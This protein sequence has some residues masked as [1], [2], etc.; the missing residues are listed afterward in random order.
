MAPPLE[1]LVGRFRFLSCSLFVCLCVCLFQRGSRRRVFSFCWF[2]CLS[3]GFLVARNQRPRGAAGG[4]GSAPLGAQ[5]RSKTIL[6]IHFRLEHISTENTHTHTHTH[7]TDTGSTTSR[8]RSSFPVPKRRAGV[9]GLG[10]EGKKT[11]K[12]KRVHFRP[13]V[14][15]KE[16]KWRRK[17]QKRAPKWL[18]TSRMQPAD[19]RA[20]HRA[21]TL[22]ATRNPLE[23][24]SGV[25]PVAKKST[26]RG[27]FR[28]KQHPTTL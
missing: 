19:G 10:S 20:E 8:C 23:T 25:E 22:K 24:V 7:K 4:R 26:E 15:K 17:P 27:H 9:E 2:V 12:K 21:P 18:T 11:S 3:V 6:P 1:C 14:A 16:K 13:R 28:L 5:W